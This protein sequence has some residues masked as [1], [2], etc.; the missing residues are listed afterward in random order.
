M[1][2]HHEEPAPLPALVWAV[3]VHHPGG[4]GSGHIRACPYSLGFGDKPENI[5]SL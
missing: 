4:R 5:W 3:R 1:T 2:N